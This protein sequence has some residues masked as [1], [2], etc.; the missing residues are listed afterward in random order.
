MISATQLE[1]ISVNEVFLT[2]SK[3]IIEVESII[4]LG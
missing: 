2:E 4:G 3:D 1:Y